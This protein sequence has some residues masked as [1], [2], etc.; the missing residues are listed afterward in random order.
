MTYCRI[1]IA[2]KDHELFGVLFLNQQHLI[3]KSKIMFRGAIDCA[4]IYTREVVKEVIACSSN[5][6]I[7]FHNHPG[8]TPSSSEADKAITRKTE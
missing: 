1:K 8:G 4:A 5:A 2:E 3:I 7:Y 6:V